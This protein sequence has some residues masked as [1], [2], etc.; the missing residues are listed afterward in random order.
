VVE[1]PDRI[2]AGKRLGRVHHRILYFVRRNEGLCVGDL[3]AI[4]AI[5]KQ[6]L[7]RPMQDLLERGL[8]RSTRSPQNM[9]TKILTLTARGAALEERLS[10][11]QRDAFRRAFRLARDCEPAWRAVMFELG[12]RRAAGMG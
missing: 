3:L 6:S 12:G 10:G 4:L 1:E 5:T 7:H 2:L 9:R 11:P 8:V